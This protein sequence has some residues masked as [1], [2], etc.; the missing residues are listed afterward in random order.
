[1]SCVCPVCVFYMTPTE[2]VHTS[3]VFCLTPI[4]I[5][6]WFSSWIEV[7]ILGLLALINNLVDLE[8]LST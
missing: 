2:H 6:E 3:M 1:M 8:A 5:V 4:I 7:Y